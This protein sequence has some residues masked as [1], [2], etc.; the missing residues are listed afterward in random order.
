MNYLRTL[1]DKIKYLLT[2]KVVYE[3][4]TLHDEL[5]DYEFA[6]DELTYDDLL[7]SDFM[8]RYNHTCTS[9]GDEMF[10]HWLRSI[11]SKEQISSLQ[12]NLQILKDHEQREKISSFLKK[13]GKQ[14]RGNIISDLWHGFQIRSFVIEHVYAILASNVLLCVL[15]SYVFP[16]F[17]PLWVIAFFMGNL[18]IYASSN[19]YISKVAGSINYLVKAVH[20]V[21]KLDRNKLHQIKYDLPEYKKFRRILWSGYLFK[22]GVGGPQSGDILSM[23]MD[24]FRVFF[25][26]EIISY[27]L[28]C[29]YLLKNIEEIRKVITFTGYYDCLLNTLHMVEEYNLSYSEISDDRPILFTDLIHPLLDNPVSQSR[30]IERGIIITG[31]N[32]AGKTTFMRS[33]GLNQL[34]ATSFGVTFSSSYTTSIRSLLTSFRINDLLLQNKSRYFAEAERIASINYAVENNPSLCLID[35]ILSGTNSD[36]RIYGSIEILKS[37]AEYGQSYVISATHDLKIAE[38]LTSLYD[39][40]YFDG[41]VEEGEIL[42]DYRLK[43][44]IVSEKNGIQILRALGIKI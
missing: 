38:S 19:Y 20:F 31:L 35:E 41:K 24:Y 29:K 11:K 30:T 36:D 43:E 37:M 22:E 26:L 14:H 23:I 12:M 21:Q 13:M 1:F 17:I 5:N 44:G 33:L 40:S 10:D 3:V 34:L 39:T 9:Y 2:P 16:H 42:F 27:K 6:I 32:M 28:T 8:K 15:L 7:L 25:C 18:F 4:R